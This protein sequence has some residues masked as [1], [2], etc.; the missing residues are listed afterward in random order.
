MNTDKLIYQ[1]ADVNST[2]S[3]TFDTGY[4]V[5]MKRSERHHYDLVQS[6]PQICD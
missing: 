5:K 3:G 2:T 1:R 6:A 4:Y